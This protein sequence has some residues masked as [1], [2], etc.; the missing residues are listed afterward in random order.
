MYDIRQVVSYS[1]VYLVPRYS[2]VG[3]STEANLLCQYCHNMPEQFRA[4]PV[5]NA[6]MA[7]FGN[8]NILSYLH[9]QWLPITIHR[10]FDSPIEQMN[11][12]RETLSRANKPTRHF[13]KRVFVSVGSVRKWKAWIDYLIKLNRKRTNRF[14]FLVDMANG[15]TKDCI[16]TVRYIVEGHS[17]Y[18]V[19][20]MAGN[21][22][23]GSGYEHLM[24]AGANFVRVGLGGGSI[25]STRLNTG[26]G[27][28]V[29]TSVLDC[30]HKKHPNAYI[31]ADGGIEHP[32]DVCKAMAAGAD[33]VMCGKLLAG[34]DLSSGDKY[35]ADGKLLSDK[36]GMCS[37]I[38]KVKY[39]RYYG[40]A[41]KTALD[42]L[43]K[44]SLGSIEGVDGLI[45]YTGT[46]EEVLG[47]ILANLRQAMTYYGG[48]TNWFDF[49]RHA[50]FVQ[51]TPTGLTEGQTRIIL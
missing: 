44:T 33:M 34:T 40:L 10:L 25:C 31:I 50:K 32:G 22:A 18:R 48:C 35:D 15:D 4:I 36:F 9:N 30:A 3:T 6:P 26:F 7:A 37:D 2:E 24:E 23:T 27:V 13:T 39:V 11:L 47:G 21:V 45:P 20:I 14:S 12:V 51:I 1:D 42:K 49:Q 46:T 28:P 41:S 43:R 38:T 17:P 19:N 8:P 29:L 16:D 5:V